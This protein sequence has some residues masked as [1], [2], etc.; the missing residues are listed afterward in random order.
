MRG[1]ELPWC[2]RGHR[3]DRSD[4]RLSSAAARARTGR[5]PLDEA[6]LSVYAP[7]PMT[8]ASGVQPVVEMP[9][10]GG[11]WRNCRAIFIPLG[12]VQE[13]FIVATNPQGLWIVDQ[14]AAHERMLF[15]RH[16]RQA[17]GKESGRPAAAD[18]DHRGTET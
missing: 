17:A 4:F 10:Y 13:S 15:E 14:H 11:N 16:V 1:P 8:G 6:A 3:K 5:L 7:P 9:A 2:L 12:Q 18:A